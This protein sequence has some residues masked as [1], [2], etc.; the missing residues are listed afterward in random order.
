MSAPVRCRGRGGAV[1]E[2][3]RDIAA[4]YATFD[5]QRRLQADARGQVEFVRTITIVD[6]TLPAP[7]ARILDVGGGPGRYAAAL[8]AQ[9]Y[10]V[11]LIDPVEKHIEQ[12]RRVS[13]EM[14]EGFVAQRGDAR[15]LDAPDGSVDA[16]LLLGPLYHLNHEDRALS[17]S[18]AM[19][20]LRPGGVLVAAAISQFAS[21]LDGLREG[22]LADEDFAAVVGGDLQTGQHTNPDPVGRPEWFTTAW[23]HHP[24]TLRKEIA[25]AGFAVETILAVE[26]PLA[27][28]VDLDERWSNKDARDWL[29]SAAETIEREPTLLGVSP[30]LLVVAYK[31]R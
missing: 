4:H 5:E 25:D 9:G 18:E 29:L 16:V 7:P 24:D 12:A 21:L 10:Q 30:H 1:L 6:R 8:A 14:A 11:T 15:K 17:L 19:R 22:W 20:V 26:G 3:D 31:P 13:D 27:L 2:L 23:F 28:L